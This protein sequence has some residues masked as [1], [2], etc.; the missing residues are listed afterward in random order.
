[1]QLNENKQI[2]ELASRGGFNPI[3]IKDAVKKDLRKNNHHWAALRYLAAD[4]IKENSE[5]FGLYDDYATL[6]AIDDMN[7]IQDNA[8]YVGNFEGLEFGEDG[9]YILH[10]FAF[11]DTDCLIASIEER[12]AEGNFV[13]LDWYLMD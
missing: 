2:K 12:D 13:S 4:Y 10:C 8:L 9:Q 11:S 3:L 6:D 5:T 7:A 1:M